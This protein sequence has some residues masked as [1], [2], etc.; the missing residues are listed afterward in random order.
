MVKLFP[1]F[2][3]LYYAL[4]GR[5]KLLVAGLLTIV[6]PFCLTTVIFGI[7][8]YHTYLLSVLPSV[9]WFRVGWNNDSLWGFWSRLFDPAPEHRARPI[10]HR[11]SVLQPDIGRRPV[12]DFLG[13]CRGAPCL[14][15]RRDTAGRKYDLTFSLAVTAMLLVSPI[16]W[17]HYL[18]ILLVPLAVVWLEL[19]AALLAR[20]LFVVTVAAFWLGYPLVWRI[21]DLNGRTATWVDSLGCSRISIMHCWRFSSWS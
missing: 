12:L 21:F 19:P 8:T 11:A 15:V 6:A 2:L 16:T 5:W 14:A 20:T 10:T 13:R 1:G 9:Q 3:L 18:L 17:E 7:G 4:R